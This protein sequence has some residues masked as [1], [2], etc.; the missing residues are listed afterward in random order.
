MTYYIRKKELQ[1]KSKYVNFFGYNIET[2]K[3]LNIK[4]FEIFMK[5]KRDFETKIL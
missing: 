4:Q 2:I 3:Q 5:H 1:L